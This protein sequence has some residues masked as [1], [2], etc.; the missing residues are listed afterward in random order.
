MRII[1][2]MRSGARFTERAGAV[3][4]SSSFFG[5]RG[6]LEIRRRPIP[7]SVS[8]VQFSYAMKPGGPERGKRPLWAAQGVFRAVRTGAKDLDLSAASRIPGFT[9]LSCSDQAFPGAGK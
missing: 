4:A 9:P 1:T 2:A 7:V 6:I 3:F 5:F 8:S